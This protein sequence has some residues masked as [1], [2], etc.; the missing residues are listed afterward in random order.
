MKRFGKAEL[1]N[2]EDFGL[3]DYCDGILYIGP[4]WIWLRMNPEDRA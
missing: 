3:F 2:R 4:F 1:W